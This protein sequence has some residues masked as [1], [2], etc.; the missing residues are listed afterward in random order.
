MSKQN[1]L[2]DLIRALNTNEKRYFKLFSSL[3]PGEKR[4]LKLFDALEGKATYNINELTKETGLTAKQLTDDKYYL[5]QALLQSLQ[6]FD[7]PN[8]SMIQLQ[9]N[10][11]SVRTLMMRRQFAFALDIL[12]RT[13]ERAWEMEA[14]EHIPEM[15]IMEAKCKFG[16][17]RYV[18]DL[19]QLS[20]Y[21]K[22]NEELEKL[23]ELQD[24][25]NT[26][27]KYHSEASNIKQYEKMLKHPLLVNGPGVLTS[28]RARLLYY[29]ILVNY[30]IVTYKRDKVAELQKDEQQLYSQYPVLKVISPVGY[31][32]ITLLRSSNE[33]SIGNHEAALALLEPMGKELEK[34]ELELTP[35]QLQSLKINVASFKLWPLRHLGRYTEAV[36]VADSIYEAVSQRSDIDRFTVMF[37][38]ALSLLLAGNVAQSLKVLDDIFGIKSTIRVDM[39]PYIR[40]I[41]LMVQISLGNYA[42]IPYQVKSIKA[43]MKKQEVANPEFDLFF[44]HILHISQSADRR[45]GWKAFIDDLTT[46]KFKNTDSLIQ[47]GEWIRANSLKRT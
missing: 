30:Y 17:S 6:N 23:F 39:Q 32:T 42:V 44:K 46:G 35:Q 4:Y 21:R 36:Q 45:T 27:R 1:Y 8:G 28:L 31:V 22:C 13:L 20:V 33:T 10:K 19:D 43:W 3:Q 2:V 15:L 34:G 18:Q 14:F 12:E 26:A 24:M 37:E 41:S 5:T 47:L 11:E 40:I 9:N 38:Y 29:E 25:A 7:R 16:L